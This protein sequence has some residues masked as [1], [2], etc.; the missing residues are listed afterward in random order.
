M[1]AITVKEAAKKWGVTTRRVQD[2]CKQG[3]IPGAQRWERTWMIPQDA[4]YPTEQTAHIESLPMPRKSPFLDMT[5]LYNAPGSADESIAALEGQPE[6]QQLLAAQIAYCR[7]QIDKVY[8]HIQFFLEAHSGF[9]AVLGGGM[10]LSLCAMWR[11]D[12]PLWQKARQHMLEAPCKNDADRDIVTMSIAAADSAIRHTEEFPEWFRRGRFGILP[13]DAH[14]AASVYYV[15]YLLFVAQDVAMQKL[16]RENVNGMNLMRF[17]PYLIEPLI[18]QASVER[19]VL[20]EIYLRLLCATVYKDL[21]NMEFANAHIDKAI[22]LALPDDLLGVLAEHRRQLGSA[23][24]D[25]LALVDQNALKRLKELHKQL[26]VGWATLHNAVL[27]RRVSTVLSPREREVA[28][29][30]AFGLTNSEIAQQL[31]LSVASVKSI[32]AMIRNKTGIVSRSEIAD[33]I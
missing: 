25:R 16:Y 31:H 13:P 4:L 8:D 26:T 14:P 27:A 24:D 28:K 3:R 9:Y 1:Y 6:A 22:A 33:Y 2:L 29:L 20:P 30:V 23:L 32:V 11:G 7:G 17:L 21:G 15:K 18:T 5:D 12:L 10:L 19:T